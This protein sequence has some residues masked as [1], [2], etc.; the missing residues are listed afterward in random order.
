M[1]LDVFY[2]KERNHVEIVFLTFLLFK[3]YIQGNQNLQPSME[4]EDDQK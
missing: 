4:V 2:S 1:I 3:K